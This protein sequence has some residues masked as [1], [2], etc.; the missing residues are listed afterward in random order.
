[1]AVEGD[2]NETMDFRRVTVLRKLQAV[3]E[4]DFGI[5]FQEGHEKRWSGCP[6]AESKGVS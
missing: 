1:M 3:L 2:E 4:N 6:A 5:E